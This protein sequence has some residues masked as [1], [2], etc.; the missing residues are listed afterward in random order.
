MN[1][2]PKCSAE[3]NSNEKFC[4]KCGAKLEENGFNDAINNVSEKFEQFNNTA[5]TTYE[6]SKDD[7]SKNRAFAILAYIGLLFLVPLLAAPN[8]PFARYHTNQGLLLFVVSTAS[9]VTAAVLSI[10][11][12][13]ILGNIINITSGTV[14]L[15]FMIIGIV[16]AAQGRAKELPIIGSIK[17]LR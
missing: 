8:S 9:S 12:L 17:I 10:I 7:I 4:P 15:I 11:G 2:C 14:T 5:D 1:K 13:G 3:L 6:Y 16:N